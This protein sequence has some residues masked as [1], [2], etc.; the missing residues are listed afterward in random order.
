MSNYIYNRLTLECDNP[1]ILD[2]FYE[3]NRNQ[4]KHI[5]LGSHDDAAL[6]FRCQVPV[7][8]GENENSI[9]GCKWDASSPEYRRLSMTQSEYLFTTPCGAPMDWIRTVS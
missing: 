3:G 8:S 6:L 2:C 4:E 9:W 5:K 7:G 1:S